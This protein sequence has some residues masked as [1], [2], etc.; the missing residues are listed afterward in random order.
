MGQRFQIYIRTPKKFYNEGN[1]NNQPA[2]TITFHHQWLYG[3]SAVEMMDWILRVVDK[4]RA[5][6]YSPLWTPQESVKFLESTCGLLNGW[7]AE[8]VHVMNE[9][10]KGKYSTEYKTFDNPDMG[11][12]NDG[13]MV[14]DLED[15]ENVC[16]S[17]GSLG[18]TE[19]EVSLSRGLYTP[20][21]YLQSYYP[22]S[23]LLKEDNRE[24]ATYEDVLLKMEP[25]GGS[26]MTE[27]M[28]RLSKVPMV[29]VERLKK[30][31]P[32]FNLSVDKEV[33]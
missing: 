6:K 16:A 14:I 3:A 11:D 28:D 12:N 8:R 27:V 1:A 18:S 29:S 15:P 19:G 10:I 9:Q 13:F 26:D 32:K 30:I 7:K 2:L 21:Q 20:L 17:F 31:F 24:D 5:D 25:R 4:N 23:K 22:L 33:A